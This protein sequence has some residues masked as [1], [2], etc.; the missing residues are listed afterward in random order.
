MAHMNCAHLFYGRVSVFGGR[1]MA[2]APY[3]RMGSHRVV[4]APEL[5]GTVSCL[6]V[7]VTLYANLVRTLA[8]PDRTDLQRRSRAAQYRFG[9]PQ[10]RFRCALDDSAQST[11]TQCRM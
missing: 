6:C 5:G 4:R 3:V 7:R 9:A 2:A 10:T 1:D 8:E 11:H